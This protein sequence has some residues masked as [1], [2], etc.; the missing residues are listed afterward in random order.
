MC[1]FKLLCIGRDEQLLESRVKILSLFYSVSA[2]P[3][4]GEST[5]VRHQHFDLVLM[6][7]S[8]VIEERRTATRLVREWW[9]NAKLLQIYV[10]GGEPEGEGFD[11]QVRGLD[12]PRALLQSVEKLL[13]LKNG[14]SLSGSG[15][16][17]ADLGEG[18]GMKNWNRRAK[19]QITFLLPLSERMKDSHALL[20]TSQRCIEAAQI[21]ISNA[22]NTLAS[23]MQ[24]I[25]TS[26]ELITM[27]DQRLRSYGALCSKGNFSA[28]AKG[29]ER[30]DKGMPMLGT[31]ADS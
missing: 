27:C 2:A 6:C 18:R 13:P 20:G 31:Q 14:D 24:R 21:S 5:K 8:L 22:R 9:P 17:P 3:G 28:G 19:D 25:T 12:G 23:S 29:A 10:G 30:L 11:A 7:H 16:K 1:N 26:H 4:I 15:R